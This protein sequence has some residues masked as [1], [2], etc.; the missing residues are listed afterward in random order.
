M[1]ALGPSKAAIIYYTLPLFSGLFAFIFLNEEINIVHF[2]SVVLII[3]G[4]FITN[5][6]SQ[7]PNKAKPQS[8]ILQP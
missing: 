7:K 4:I 3:S 1:I 6:V 5:Y 2:Y 8:C